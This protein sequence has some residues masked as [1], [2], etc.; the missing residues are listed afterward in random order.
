M[1]SATEREKI[2]LEVHIQNLTQDAIYFERMRLECTDGWEAVDGNSFLDEDGNK[3]SIY[4]GSMALLQPQDM[5]QYVYILT[6]KNTELTPTVYA[7]GSIIPLGRLDISWRSSFGEP[8]RLLTSMLSRRIPL[9]PAPQPASALPP[10]LKRTVPVSSPS[11][12][13]SPSISQSSRPATPPPIP[14]PGSPALNRA[15]MSS[16]VQPQSPHQQ[17]VAPISLL[18]DLEAQLL[19]RHIPRDNIV[20]EKGFSIAFAVILTSNIIPGAKEHMRRRVKLAIQH[21]RP[22]KAPPPV[23]S[24]PVAPEAFSPRIPSSGFSTPSSSTT[25]FN[26]A[27]AHQKILAV[28]S[29]PPAQDP[30]PL[31]IDISDGDANVLPPP[32]FEDE[33]KYYT[34]TGVSFIGSSAVFLPVIELNFSNAQSKG[35]GLPKVQVVHEFELS[36]VALRTGFS[37]IGG[38]RI[39]LVEDHLLQSVEEEEEDR[40]VKPKRAITLKEYDVIGEVWVSV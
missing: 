13:H 29:Q 11:R 18:P 28:S 2:F 5:R 12:P 15:S 20:V 17:S 10:H 19:V 37:T 26:Y 7:P 30:I 16:I 22:R 34:P 32:Y 9:A 6:P 23:I 27:L 8:G 3:T 1:L 25:T 35:E 4:S 31:E 14:R 24:S 40:K 21:L 38:I 33:L 39:L 36:F